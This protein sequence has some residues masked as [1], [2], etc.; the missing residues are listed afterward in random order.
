MT[1]LIIAE[2]E[3]AGRTIAQILG[4]NNFEEK[5]LEGITYFQFGDTIVVPAMGHLLR[6]K[7][8]GWKSAKIDELPLINL[9]WKIPKKNLIRVRII[10]RL[11]QNCESIIGATD[12]DR[13]GE[14]IFYNL[15]RKINRKLNELELP[16]K[17][18][19]MYFNSLVED[20]ITEAYQNIVPMDEQLLVQG[21]ARNFADNCIGVNLSKALTLRCKEK[22]QFLKQGIPLGRVKSPLL[23]FISESS[24]IEISE[25]QETHQSTDSTMLTYV[26]IGQSYYQIE[27]D[28]EQ[29]TNLP[30][31][32]K[33]KIS[34]IKEESEETEQAEELFNTNDILVSIEGIDPETLMHILENLYL[35]GY[36]TYPRTKS[37]WV[38]EKKLAKLEQVIREYKELPED[39]GYENCPVG[40]RI[41]KKEAIILTEKGIRA[42]CEGRIENKGEEIVASIILNR[43]IKSFACPL[44][45]KRILFD[46]A[47]GKEKYE[48]IVWTEE[49]EN[50]PLSLD[51][52]ESEI[53]PK[54]KKGD[55][56][57]VVLYEK[58]ENVSNS[59][60][61]ELDVVILSDIDLVR[62]MTREN[63]GTEATRA[64]FAGELR[65]NHYISKSN[66]P[67]ILGE[68]VAEI[69]GS[70][71]LDSGVTA[72][73][74]REI[75]KLESL[76]QLKEFEKWVIDL[77][78]DFIKK[79]KGVEIKFT[80]PEN[81]KAELVDTRNGLALVCKLCNPKGRYYNL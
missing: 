21:L 51:E 28:A 63:M 55:Y 26:K 70:I 9:G 10:E 19:R 46:L 36:A 35:K 23:F 42:L 50:L 79:L 56:D 37:K 4:K 15:I 6:A 58:T 48:K 38:D 67:T 52:E 25:E 20:D 60:L 66:L 41:E 22:F 59:P 1:E 69:I 75:E 11:A 73:I 39:F 81:H 7:M 71:G 49:I 61:F 14:V 13:E 3:E 43:M 57:L 34:N 8:K 74:E 5:E 65:K 32:N 77:T 72:D 68:G 78:A 33:A 54:L 80:C 47:I 24:G 16:T 53:R 29:N 27:V 62:W 44:E 64:T 30:L 2:K 18:Q 40:E 45:R 76:E 31:V 12:F 17:M